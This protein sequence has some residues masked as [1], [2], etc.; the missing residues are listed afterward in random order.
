MA[1]VKI[2]EV[3]LYT[4]EGVDDQAEMIRA[5]AFMDSSGI[6]YIH[7][8]YN[9]I[10]VTQEVL[11]N[12]NTWWER[13]DI[14]LPPIEHYPFITYTEVHDDIPA[15]YSPVKYKQGIADIET[16]PEFYN[17]VMSQ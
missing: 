4:A 12:I 13:P 6:P 7:L 5:K 16:F 8:S 1:L 10:N 2:E 14:N 17:S 15:R 3:Y 11:T 9:D